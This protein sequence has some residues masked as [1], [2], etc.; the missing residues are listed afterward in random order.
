MRRSTIDALV[1]H[2][3]FEFNFFLLNGYAIANKLLIFT[4]KLNVK[5]KKEKLKQTRD[6]TKM[7]YDNPRQSCCSFCLI[8]L[9]NAF[10]F[11]FA[12]YI[13]D[14]REDEFGC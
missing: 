3:K 4:N 2:G 11:T 8:A 12:I 5:K 1:V 14:K 10:L 7:L 13:Y 6:I 9:I